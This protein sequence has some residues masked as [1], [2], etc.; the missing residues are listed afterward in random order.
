[1][2]YD[3]LN[4]ALLLAITGILLIIMMYSP[5]IGSEPDK[6]LKAKCL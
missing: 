3:I 2:K 6:Y 4:A 5:V 1:M